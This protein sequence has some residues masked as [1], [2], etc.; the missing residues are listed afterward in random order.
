MRNRDFQLLLTGRTLALVGGAMTS[1]TLMLLAMDV[2]GSPAVSSMVVAANFVGNICASLPAGVVADRADRKKIMV[3]ASVSLAILLLTLPIAAAVAAVKVPHLVVVSFGVGVAGMFYSPAEVSAVKLIVRPD[4][5]AQARVADQA[6]W[7]VS[8]LVG[9][10]LA[11]ILYGFGRY[12]PIVGD[13]VANLAAAALA[14]AVRTDL[15]TKS[16]SRDGRALS[17]LKEGL[18]WLFASPSARICALLTALLNFGTLSLVTVIMLELKL[19]DQNA[20][21]VSLVPVAAGVGA[22]AGALA[23]PR[24]HKRFPL[25]ALFIVSL[26]VGLGVGSSLFWLRSPVAVIVILCLSSFCVPVGNIG[27]QSWV[28]IVTPQEFQGRVSA[29]LNICSMAMTP[30]ATVVAGVLLGS[31]GF[32]AGIAPALAAIL[33]CVATGLL[34]RPVRTLPRMSEVV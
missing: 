20:T 29:A 10:P 34:S 1:L 25:G 2:T 7:S 19:A 14:G 5:I 9:T 28:M 15:S 21:T 26:S 32:A 4:Q 16:T 18:R 33:G 11:G 27:L 30:V 22:L 3:I 8:G 13:A 23:T 17:D 12:W 24:F 6:R 31:H